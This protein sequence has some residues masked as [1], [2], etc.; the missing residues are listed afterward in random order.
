MFTA[1][2]PLGIETLS[3]CGRGLFPPESTTAHV[4]PS[5]GCR[6]HCENPASG[7]S[8]SASDAPGDDVSESPRGPPKALCT[9]RL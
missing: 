9:H 4:H 3:D 6:V 5:L 1:G 7:E 2:S 8:E